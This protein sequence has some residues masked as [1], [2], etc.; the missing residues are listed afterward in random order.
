[1]TTVT[2][3]VSFA[4]GDQSIAHLVLPFKNVVSHFY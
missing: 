2:V 3:R 4:F 1:M